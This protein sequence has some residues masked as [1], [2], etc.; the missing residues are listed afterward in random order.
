MKREIWARLA[1]ALIL[2]ISVAAFAFNGDPY[3]THSWI[4]S[5]VARIAPKDEVARAE[6][7]NK[8]I[9]E[10][11]INGLRQATRPDVLNGA[12]WGAVA[13][14]ST[15][16]PR[17]QPVSVAPALYSRTVASGGVDV[18]TIVLTSDYAGGEVA[19]STIYIDNLSGKVQG[20]NVTVYSASD[21]RALGFDPLHASMTQAAFLI[22]AVL[23]FLF[24]LATAYK[25]LATPKVKW[26]WLWFIFIM[27]GV[28]SIRLNWLTQAVSVA[29]IDIRWGAAGYWQ[30]L[31][32]T[33]TIYVN[34]PLGAVM[35]WMMRRRLASKTP[36]RPERRLTDTHDTP[37]DE[38][39]MLLARD[40][41]GWKELYRQ[42]STGRLIE[43]TWPN[44]DEHGGGQSQYTIIS[45]A[46][47]RARYV[48]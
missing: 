28:V 21:R 29:P 23:V 14:I 11:D 12:F 5:F 46:D 38:G 10:Q 33:V 44:S 35:Y 30:A 36:H 43:K 13:K 24:T 16:Y 47:A 1:C 2:M 19:L 4:Y 18:S 6:A 8:L 9:R 39:L 45:E 41:S 15:L 17:T 31:F 37:L 27:A 26:K 48:F 7:Y 32:G 3:N 20:F 34:F 25:C 42:E 22:M 40:A